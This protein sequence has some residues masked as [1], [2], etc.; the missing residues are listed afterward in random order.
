MTTELVVP[1]HTTAT[2]VQLA[3]AYYPLLVQVAQQRGQITYGELVAQA[4]QAYPERT[5][6]QS[7]IAVSAGRRLDVVRMFT[8]S[9]GL[10]DLTALVI[11][12]GAGECGARYTRDHDPAYERAQVYAYD[13]SQATQE[14]AG[15]VALQQH[16][17]R[18]QALRPRKALKE[19]A[20]LAAMSA[21]YQ[22]HKA[23]LPAHIVQHR[24]QIVARLM[25]GDSAE[26]AFEA[27]L[28]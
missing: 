26:A 22:A 28:L 14:F 27:V 13:W 15:Y 12:K 8:Q 11:N 6:V 4:K 20:A 24:A 7:A 3:A 18:Q 19:D 10:P 23:Q 1:D 5:E 17:L 9:Q 21:Y 2:D 25:A 16:A